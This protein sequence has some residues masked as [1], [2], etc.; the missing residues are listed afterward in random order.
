[1]RVSKPGK[2]LG[3]PLQVM[4][5]RGMGKVGAREELV[6]MARIFEGPTCIQNYQ[7]EDTTEFQDPHDWITGDIS[8]SVS[9][10]RSP[11]K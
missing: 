10:I 8:F 6:S 2:P 11:V 5:A 1:M 4:L 3:H 7:S 9:I